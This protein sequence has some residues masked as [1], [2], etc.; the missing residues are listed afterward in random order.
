MNRYAKAAKRALQ[1]GV[2][3]GTNTPLSVLSDAERKKHESVL[4]KMMT[5]EVLMRRSESIAGV[6]KK[7]R[8]KLLE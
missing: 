5:R 8:P 3:L 7:Y 6:I 1:R 2:V 4:E